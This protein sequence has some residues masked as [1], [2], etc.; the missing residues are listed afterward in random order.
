[1]GIKNSV[2]VAQAQGSSLESKG[3]ESTEQITYAEESNL[4]AVKNGKKQSETS[5][6]TVDAYKKLLVGDGKKIISLGATFASLDQEI[7][8][9][10][11]GK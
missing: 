8:Q 7:S 11:G 5:K 3:Q 9:H 6:E 4:T 2:E 1:M 10:F